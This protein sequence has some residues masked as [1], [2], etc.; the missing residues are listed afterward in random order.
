MDWTANITSVNSD[1]NN[2]GM[3]IVAVDYTDGNQT[4]GET[5]SYNSVNLTDSSQ[6]DIQ[7]QQ[8]LSAFTGFASVVAE[9]TAKINHPVNLTQNSLMAGTALQ[10]VR[11][12]VN[13]AV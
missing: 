12:N 11:L 8:R 1:P 2:P 9:I 4:V 3:I 6:V 7:I 10:S 13:K 5:Y